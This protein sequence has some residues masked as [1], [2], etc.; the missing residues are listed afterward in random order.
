[1]YSPLLYLS[2][3][4]ASM[5]LFLT[6]FKKFYS[7]LQSVL[8]FYHMQFHTLPYTIVWRFTLPPK[9]VTGMEIISGSGIW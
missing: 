6:P 9:L 5:K 1:M 8:L 4:D 2:I 3:S 7:L